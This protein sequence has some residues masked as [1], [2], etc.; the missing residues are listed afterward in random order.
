DWDA[1]GQY[2]INPVKRTARTLW[3]L[4]D[5][6]NNLYLSWMEKCITRADAI[7]VVSS[8]LQQR[9]GGVMLP[10]GRD[11]Q[12]LNPANFDS[13]AL[14]AQYGLSGKF[15]LMFFG[16]PRPHKGLEDVLNAMQRLDIP[17]LCFAVVGVNWE[18]AYTQTLQ[19][20]GEPRLRLFGMQPW[21][22]IPEFLAMADAVILAQRPLPFGQA[23]VPAKVFDAMAMAKP[24]IATQVGDL[25]DI[26]NGCGYLVPPNNINSLADSIRHIY[27]HPEEAYQLGQSARI[28]CQTQYSWDVMEKIL[29]DIIHNINNSKI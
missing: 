26:L 25:P 21:T 28:R 18:D 3:H 4:P 17:E 27:E 10:H 11:T 29:E 2:G 14:K 20:H 6:Y 7:T 13:E 19:K 1:E 22:K 5:P 16:T 8:E 15:V 24:V 12:T 9:F 23:Q